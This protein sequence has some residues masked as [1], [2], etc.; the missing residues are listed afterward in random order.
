ME[1]RPESH[2]Y[3]KELSQESLYDPNELRCTYDVLIKAISVQWSNPLCHCLPDTYKSMLKRALSIN[4][5]GKNRKRL[6]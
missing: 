6:L 3:L 5:S 2:R 4:L 1:Y